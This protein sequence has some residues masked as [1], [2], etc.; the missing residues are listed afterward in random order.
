MVRIYCKSKVISSGKTGK[1]WRLHIQAD[2]RCW[3]KV[4]RSAGF[5]L[6][7]SDRRCQVEECSQFDRVG[8]H[9]NLY[10][11]VKTNYVIITRVM[12]KI[13]FVQMDSVRSGVKK[14]IPGGA[15]SLC[16]RIP[17]RWMTIWNPES[18]YLICFV[19]LEDRKKSLGV[20]SKRV[21]G[22][23]IFNTVEPYCRNFTAYCGRLKGFMTENAQ[24]TDEKIRS[25]SPDDKYWGAVSVLWTENLHTVDNHWHNQ[26]W[27]KFIFILFRSTAHTTSCLDWLM[28]TK[29]EE[30]IRESPTNC[31]RL[32][33]FLARL[34]FLSET[35]RI[36]LIAIVCCLEWLT[37]MEIS[38]TWR[39]SWTRRATP[40]RLTESAQDWS[41]YCGKWPSRLLDSNELF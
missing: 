13:T 32:R 40:L 28:D 19:V 15:P 38:M 33:T 41:R 37:G 9:N 31:T 25:A 4:D 3:R 22:Y 17:G 11:S 6:Q 14:R 2:V 18:V 1:R 36:I 26:P 35:I 12:L 16:C 8:N 10:L 34:F 23:H 5:R 30:S 39:R 27:Q 7:I 24:W 21:L 20:L 29:D